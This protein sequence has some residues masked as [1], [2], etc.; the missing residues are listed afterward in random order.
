MP[1]DF[2]FCQDRILFSNSLAR[3]SAWHREGSQSIFVDRNKLTLWLQ[4]FFFIKT[5]YIR[6]Y[7]INPPLIETLFP[8]LY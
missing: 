1:L 6:K 3:W 8:C 2:E 7:L 5:S 4:M